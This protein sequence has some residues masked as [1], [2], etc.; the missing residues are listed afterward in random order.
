MTNLT[1]EQI[2]SQLNKLPERMRLPIRHYAMNLL[3]D[4][5]AQEAGTSDISAKIV[6]L[7]K[8]HG[9]FEEI[10]MQYMEYLFC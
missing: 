6:A 3:Q 4:E 10:L 7:Y 1:P 9:S 5:G 8:Q 2:I